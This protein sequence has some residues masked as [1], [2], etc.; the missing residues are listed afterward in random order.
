MARTLYV[1]RPLLNAVEFLAHY[2]AQ[3]FG[4]MLAPEDLHV[5]IAYS[6]DAIEWD[7]VRRAPPSLVAGSDER[8][9]IALGDKGAVV[10]TFE[11]PALQE[12]WGE[13]RTA[14]ASWDWP[15]FQPHVTITYNG[16]GIDLSKI[17]PFPDP[18][19]F[20]PEV[21]EELNLDWKP[22]MKAERPA[23]EAIAILLPVLVKARVPDASGRRIVEVEAS[24]ES[25]DADGDVILQRALIDAAADFVKSGHLDLDHLSEFGDRL[26][27]PDPAGFIIGR[28]TE[29]KDL[30]GGRTGVVGEIRRSLDGRHDPKRNRYDAF[31]DSLQ[32]D[33]PVLWQASVYGFPKAG[34]VRDCSDGSCPDTGARRY[35][36]EGFE[37]RSLAFTRQP[38]NQAITGFARIVTAKSL[39]AD[40]LRERSAAGGFRDMESLFKSQTCAKCGVHKAPTSVGYREHFAKCEAVPAPMAE[41]YANAL[42]HGLT[43]ARVTVIRHRPAA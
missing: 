11:C 27:L 18:L 10:T 36:V 1:N 34:M 29:V 19:I 15:S 30:G 24:N 31:W 38:K 17:E 37:W 8:K 42:M 33:P 28:P 9:V 21:W 25:V 43:K 13:F 14:G 2:R 6:R 23:E 4:L 40:A 22:V 12:R 16:D 32:S 3:G 5:T 35:L 26:G 20:G 41:V 7:R 39:I